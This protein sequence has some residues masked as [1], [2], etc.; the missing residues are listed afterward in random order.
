MEWM[1]SVICG[2]LLGAAAL[3]MLAL[4]QGAGYKISPNKKFMLRLRA[5]FILT[6]VLARI[7]AA[8]FIVQ[9]VTGAAYVKLIFFYG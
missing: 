4:V 1:A 2:V 6:L 3:D 9:A 7:A 5:Q 8:L